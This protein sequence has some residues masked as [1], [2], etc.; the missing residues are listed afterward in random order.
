VARYPGHVDAGRCKILDHE[1]S[2]V[3]VLGH[4]QRVGLYLLL[5]PGVVLESLV[6]DL[7]PV[8]GRKASCVPL[9]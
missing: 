8:D 9:E 4:G 7:E 2:G 1:G 3:D 6:L 5:V